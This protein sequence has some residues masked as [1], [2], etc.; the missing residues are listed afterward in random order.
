MFILIF[1]IFFPSVARGSDPE[2]FKKSKEFGVEVDKGL[3]ANGLTP[4]NPD[5][6]QQNL[7]NH[8]AFVTNKTYVETG[9]TVTSLLRL[10]AT[11]INFAR[12]AT[13]MNTFRQ[14][15]QLTQVAADAGAWTRF[16]AWGGNLGSRLRIGAIA[17]SEPFAGAL[18]GIQKVIRPVGSLLSKSPGLIKWIGRANNV[19]A[20]VGF[21]MSIYDCYSDW[22]AAAKDGWSDKAVGDAVINTTCTAIGAVVGTTIGCFIGCPWLGL[23]IGTS[24]GNLAGWGLKSILPDSWKAGIGAGAKWV[25]DK[26]SKLLPW[27]WG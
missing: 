5:N 7:A 12:T 1:D 17:F 10:S 18:G 25:V 23:F 27:N 6:P 20:F 14:G 19:L 3:K 24:L 22:D 26:A 2:E 21:A 16:L 15:I 13:T 11:P 9:V 4:E 8:D